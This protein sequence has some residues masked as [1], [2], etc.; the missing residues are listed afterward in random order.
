MARKPSKHV[1]SPTDPSLPPERAIHL[2]RIQCEKGKQLLQSR[3]ISD[4]Q[5]Q[6][7]KAVTE[8]ILKKSFGSTSPQ[9]SRVMDVGQ[10]KFAFGGGSERE[11]EQS[12]AEG[13]QS[14]LTIME[15]LI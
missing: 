13:M 12:R 4:D 1:P 2:L 9:V 10:Y 3:P 15:S 8:E 6:A 11:H 7:W 14:R 5:E